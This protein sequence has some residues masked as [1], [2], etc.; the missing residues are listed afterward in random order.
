MWDVGSL[1]KKLVEVE[2]QIIY[3]KGRQLTKN[4]FEIVTKIYDQI[5]VKIFFRKSSKLYITLFRLYNN[6]CQFIYTWINLNNKII[7]FKIKSDSWKR[8]LI[9]Y[10]GRGKEICK[11]YLVITRKVELRDY[12]FKKFYIHKNGLFKILVN[13]KALKDNVFSCVF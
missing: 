13:I 11:S 6:Q 5:F 12:F 8:H 1:V 9:N 10:W 7:E 3:D 4:L 2:N